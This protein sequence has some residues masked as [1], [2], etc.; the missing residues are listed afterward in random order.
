MLYVLIAFV[1]VCGIGLY[2]HF[3][4]ADEREQADM[5]RCHRGICD[6]TWEDEE[7]HDFMDMSYMKHKYFKRQS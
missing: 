2:L 1:V 7:Y 6:C 4:Y 5:Y 3:V